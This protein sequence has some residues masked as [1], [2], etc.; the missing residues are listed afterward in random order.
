MESKRS[1][2]GT[3]NVLVDLGFGP[4]G[5]G[6][7]TREDGSPMEIVHYA[8]TRAQWSARDMVSSS[9]VRGQQWLEA[10]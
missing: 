8:M 2:R 5:E 1:L 9:S 3:D 6:L 7:A 10:A 4:F